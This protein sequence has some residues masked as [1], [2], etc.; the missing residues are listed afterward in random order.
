MLVHNKV[1]WRVRP[2]NT[3]G[4]GALRAEVL[5][6]GII[7]LLVGAAV[8]GI[9]LAVW[10]SAVADVN[11]GCPGSLHDV[12]CPSALAKASTFAG[13]AFVGGILCVVGLILTVLGAVWKRETPGSSALS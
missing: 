1:L 2:L 3:I 5:L 9:G 8:G 11:S 6:L 7:I 12:D 10:N 13:V 4:E